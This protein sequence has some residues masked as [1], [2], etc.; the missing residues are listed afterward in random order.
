M[1]LTA[2]S[3]MRDG[4]PRYAARAVEYYDECRRADRRLAF[5][6][7]DAK[8]DRALGPAQ[9]DDPDLYVRVVARSDDGVVVR[10]AKLHISNCAI[11]HDIVVMP[12][13]RMHAGE[14][15]W[16]FAGVVPVSTPGVVVVSTSHAPEPGQSERFP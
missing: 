13:K 2:A 7:T 9:Q 15:Q 16:A 10:G 4:H 3:R 5:A 6:I 11:V 14:E 8:G 1:V 12:T